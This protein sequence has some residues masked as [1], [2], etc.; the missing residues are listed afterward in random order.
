MERFVETCGI[1]CSL[2]EPRSD[3]LYH[4]EKAWWQGANIRLQ[5]SYVELN[6]DRR[7][8][9]DH[10]VEVTAVSR[11]WVLPIAIDYD[12]LDKRVIDGSA[13]TRETRRLP[14]PRKSWAIVGRE[15]EYSG[16]EHIIRWKYLRPRKLRQE[17]KFGPVARANLNEMLAQKCGL[18]FFHA[19]R[20]LAI[21]PVR[22]PLWQADEGRLVTDN[23][24]PIVVLASFGE[25]QKPVHLHA[26][27][28]ASIRARAQ[29]SPSGER[30][31]IDR[32]G[33]L[34]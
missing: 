3:R 30:I 8:V 6:R 20:Y 11:R 21:R 22:R 31:P 23:R 27:D 18:L 5:P 7:I 32:R 16:V 15:S 26:R 2:P 29:N 33:G 13:D 9:F 34:S 12:P 17:G 10:R 14:R 24:L 25:A 4:R 1:P 28:R 19:K